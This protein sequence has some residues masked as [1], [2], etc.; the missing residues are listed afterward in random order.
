MLST[1]VSLYTLASL[2]TFEWLVSMEYPA[3]CLDEKV[4]VCTE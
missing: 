2:E 4:L 3:Q 1:R